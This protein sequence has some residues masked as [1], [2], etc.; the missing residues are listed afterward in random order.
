MAQHQLLLLVLTVMVV[1]VSMVMGLASYQEN[2][3]KFE[4]E[5]AY[6]AMV[7]LAGK[8]MAYRRTPESLNGGTKA[9]GVASF[10]GFT[11][12]KVGAI[13][14]EGDGGG[15]DLLANGS[16]FTGNA[17]SDGSQFRAAWYPNGDCD[18]SSNIVL[19]MIVSGSEPDDISIEDGGYANEWINT[20]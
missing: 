11:M 12:E 9:N 19:R 2:Q 17:N 8:A 13:L 14:R 15:Y 18:S 10:E 5:A 6:M 16:C 1:G 20:K 3:K 7:D 4:R